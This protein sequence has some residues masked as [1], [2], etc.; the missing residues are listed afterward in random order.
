VDL[1]ALEARFFV[2]S[3]KGFKGALESDGVFFFTMDHER[4]TLDLE[5]REFKWGTCS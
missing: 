4:W 3:L 2:S 1:T 5:N